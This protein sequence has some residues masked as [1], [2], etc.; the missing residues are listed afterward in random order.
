MSNFEVRAG[1]ATHVK[2]SNRGGARRPPSRRGL[3]NAVIQLI[4]A[5]LVLVAAAM[6]FVASRRSGAD[7]SP[8]PASTATSG[9]PERTYG[10][11]LPTH[12]ATPTPDD[13][14]TST[15][16]INSHSFE[17]DNTLEV[18]VVVEVLGKPVGIVAARSQATLSV[19]ASATEAAWRT[20]PTQL[21]GRLVGEEL[22]AEFALPVQGVLVIDHEIGAARYAFIRVDNDS[23]EDCR[24]GVGTAVPE[25]GGFPYL[26]PSGSEDVDLGYFEVERG[27]AVRALCDPSGLALRWGKGPRGHGRA[28]EKMIQSPSG[29]VEL[30]IP[31]RESATP[32]PTHSHTLP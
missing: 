29:L 13:E 11:P 26:V 32:G 30:T 7:P 16:A 28:L 9:T 18:D 14:P 12:V 15:L 24:F 21:D 6:P 10:P 20:L 23:D 4:A 5:I 19:P 17:A 27:T 22:T 25:K 3:V 31:A 1:G 8:R 2:F